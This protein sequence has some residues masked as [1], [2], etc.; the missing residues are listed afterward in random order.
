MKTL[1]EIILDKLYGHLFHFG[2]PSECGF[3][4]MQVVQT[5]HEMGFRV[6]TPNEHNDFELEV[7]DTFEFVVLTDDEL[8]T[9]LEVVLFNFWKQPL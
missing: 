6:G 5:L 1:R 8:V 7:L 4:W 2:K 3:K 9:M